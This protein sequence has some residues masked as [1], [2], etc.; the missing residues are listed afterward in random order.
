MYHFNFGFTIVILCKFRKKLC[1][2]LIKIAPYGDC[3]HVVINW[4]LSPIYQ[5]NLNIKPSLPLCIFTLRHSLIDVNFMKFHIR[6]ASSTVI[7]LYKKNSYGVEDVVI[8]ILFHFKTHGNNHLTWGGYWL[9]PYHCSASRIFITHFCVLCYITLHETPV[10]VVLN[11][12][13]HFFIFWLHIY[14]N[15][16]FKIKK[17]RGTA[18]VGCCYHMI[19]LLWTRACWIKKDEMK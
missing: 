1:I 6:S 18:H 15:K 19:V 4:T 16:N 12:S 9:F 13:I 17:S 8:E 3:S 10:L 5:W 2:R 14:F 11:C 7:C